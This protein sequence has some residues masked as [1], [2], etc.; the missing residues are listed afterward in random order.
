MREAAE[1]AGYFRGHGEATSTP[2]EFLDAIDAE[3][4]GQKRYPEGFEGHKT[5]GE[6]TA[7]GAREQHAYDALHRGIE[8]DL[9]AAGH[10]GLGPDVKKRAVELMRDEGMHPDE[11]VDHA[12]MQLDQEDMARGAPHAPSDFP[13]DRAAAPKPGAD[14]PIDLKTMDEAR[15]QL[16]S[17]F[18]DAKEKAIAGQGGSDLRAMSK[19]LHE[20][21]NEIA[22]ALASGKF[23]GD[24]AL[25]A[26]LQKEARAA[27]AEYRQTFSS[28]GPGDEIGRAVEKILGRYSDTA[29]TAEDIQKLSYGPKGNP[30]TGMSSKIAGRLQQILGKDSA[31]YARW[32]QGL[33][34]YVDDRSLPVL[35]R[36]QRIDEFLGTSGARIALEPEERTA[37]AAYSK[38]LRATAPSKEKLTDLQKDIARISGADGNRMTVDE[39]TGKL[40]EKG[41]ENLL[42]HLKDAA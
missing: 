4:R 24:A 21:D 39:V 3:L 32:K 1:E 38:E 11:A 31:G 8:D 40:L 14:R 35:E 22:D 2:T 30:G 6:K 27:H 13:G 5:A 12:I 41:S 36:A 20:F 7:M 26:K 33:F 17:M 16:G 29:A 9:A 18:R 10:G 42:L 19:I 28:R 23:S 34:H 15:K 37:M 25:A